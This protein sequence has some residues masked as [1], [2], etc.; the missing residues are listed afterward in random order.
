MLAKGLEVQLCAFAD[1]EKHACAEFPQTVI[2]T[3]DRELYV[4]VRANMKR[5]YAKLW[6]TIEANKDHLS[7]EVWSWR[8]DESARADDGVSKGNFAYAPL[9]HLPTPDGA[10][11]TESNAVQLWSLTFLAITR[12]RELEA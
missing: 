6:D 5:A 12:R 10:G 7:S 9:S 1:A 4:R 8:W 2:S 11:Q 3:D